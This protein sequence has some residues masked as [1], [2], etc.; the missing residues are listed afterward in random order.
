MKKA[1]HQLTLA[2]SFLSLGA[3]GLAGTIAH[4]A[5]F[6]PPRPAETIEE[7]RHQ[8]DHRN[9]TEGGCG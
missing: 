9:A 7:I 8:V 3:L 6:A 1:V 2:F 4:A 5:N